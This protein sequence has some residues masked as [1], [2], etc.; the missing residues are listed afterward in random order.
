MVSIGHTLGFQE[1]SFCLSEGS[2]TCSEMCDEEEPQESLSSL[3]K[4][5]AGERDKDCLGCRVSGGWCFL[6]DF[7][8]GILH[9]ESSS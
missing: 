4:R 2:S 6:M 9:N 5:G 7:T 8:L 1:I 3:P